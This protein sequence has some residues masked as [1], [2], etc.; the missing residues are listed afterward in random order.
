MKGHPL[1][2]TN[3]LAASLT[4]EA[5]FDGLSGKFLWKLERVT[6]HRDL[7]TA[8]GVLRI[9]VRTVHPAA[10]TFA[11][12]ENEARAWANRFRPDGWELV[13]A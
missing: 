13:H 7:P 3:S 4:V 1:H 8:E 12:T 10:G 2:G 9:P 6:G 5:R 11:G